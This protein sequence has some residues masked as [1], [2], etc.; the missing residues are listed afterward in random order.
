MVELLEY[1]RLAI[2]LDDDDAAGVRLGVWGPVAGI[3]EIESAI[4]PEGEVVGAVELHPV[5]IRD[6]DLDFA[7]VAGLLDRG[8]A[9]DRRDPAADIRSLGGV[10]AA[11][12]AEHTGVRPATN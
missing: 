8:R 5:G 7:L 6:Q 2:L 10:D 9:M 12:S 11:V 4:R 1:A 3:G